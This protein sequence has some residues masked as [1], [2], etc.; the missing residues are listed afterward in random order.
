MGQLSESE[1]ALKGKNG[2]TYCPLKNL[3]KELD[4]LQRLQAK[5][6]LGLQREVRS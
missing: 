4:F 6:A 5:R 2:S 1:K 3:Q